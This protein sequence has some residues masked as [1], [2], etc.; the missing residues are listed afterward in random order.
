MFICP[1]Y[2]VP[3][4]REAND[5]GTC[6]DVVGL[7]H[8]RH[9]R[10]LTGVPQQV[11]HDHPR[12]GARPLGQLEGVLRAIENGA[13][14]NSVQKRL[15]ELAAQQA[16]LLEQLQATDSPA[17]VVRLHPNA[18]ALYAAKI[19]DL[20]AALNQPDIFYWKTSER[21]NICGPHCVRKEVNSRWFRTVTRF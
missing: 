17:P 1:Q 14:N 19:A 7:G 3:Y 21:V 10:R 13:W 4:G 11:D 15:N 5:G 6:P 8:Y 12:H 20:Q 16:E 18:A 2:N 9:S